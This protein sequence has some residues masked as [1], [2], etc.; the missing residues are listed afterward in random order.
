[1]RAGT[2]ARSGNRVCKMATKEL[3]IHTHTHTSGSR[4]LFFARQKASLA[5]CSACLASKIPLPYCPV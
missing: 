4:D 3:Y 2:R 5:N 1:M